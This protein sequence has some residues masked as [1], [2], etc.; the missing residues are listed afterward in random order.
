[1]SL[2]VRYIPY[3]LV[4]TNFTGPWCHKKGIQVIK[5]V[6][7]LL[8][9]EKRVVGLIIA[10]IV[11]TITAIAT[12]ATASVALSQGIQNAYY[13]NTLIQNVTYALQQQVS[14]DEKN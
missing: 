5:E 7:S 10:G 13:I 2:A 14:I 6:K 3:L 4:P 8:V 12:M 1:M 9:R 11:A